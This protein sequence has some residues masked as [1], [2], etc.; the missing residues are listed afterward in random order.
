MPSIVSSSRRE[1]S[2]WSGFRRSEILIGDGRDERKRIKK[3]R[4]GPGK[5]KAKQLKEGTLRKRDGR[6]RVGHIIDWT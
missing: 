1:R 6:T 4:K 2:D 5:D 3:R